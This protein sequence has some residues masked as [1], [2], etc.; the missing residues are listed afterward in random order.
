MSVWADTVMVVK[1]RQ[2][3][4]LRFLQGC[5]TINGDMSSLSLSKKW[6]WMELLLLYIF[7]CSGLFSMW[8]YIFLGISLMYYKQWKLKDAMCSVQLY[9]LFAYTGK[10][11]NTCTNVKSL[12]QT[13][14]SGSNLALNGILFLFTFCATIVKPWAHQNRDWIMHVEKNVA[15]KNYPRGSV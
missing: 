2:A 5:F 11:K 4:Y 15:K 12:G 1:M 14:N 6:K 7:C 13:L 10:F 3:H 9:C 8:K